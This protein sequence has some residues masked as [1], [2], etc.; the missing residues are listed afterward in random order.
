[1]HNDEAPELVCPE[2]L[3]RTASGWSLLGGRCASCGEICFPA[4]RSCAKCC[5]TSVAAWEIGDRGTL[6][7]W[8]IQGFLP[9]SP[10]DS[11]E[12]ESTF[13]PYGVGYVQMPSGLKVES[14]LTVSDPRRLQIGAP[15]ALILQPYRTKPDGHQVFTFAFEPIA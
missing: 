6:W 5:G 11:G 15:M 7:S 12:T 14:R 8:T 9:K 2:L 3:R 1:M 13:R 4:Q 10:Y